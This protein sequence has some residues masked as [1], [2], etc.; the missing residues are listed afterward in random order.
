MIKAAEMPVKFH[1]LYP[2]DRTIKEKIESIARE[3]YGAD[4][5]DYSP[6]AEERIASYTRLG[7]D[8][9]PICMAKTHLSLS[10][11]PALKGVPKGYRIPVRDVRASVGAGFL[12]PL[13]GKMSTMPGLPTRPIFMEIDIEPETGKIIGLS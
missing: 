6:E 12:Y 8:K 7:F 10:H 4:G 9:L 2:L 5:V 3:V 1:F 11:D 13:L